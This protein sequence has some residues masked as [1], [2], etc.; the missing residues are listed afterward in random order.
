LVA[1]ADGSVLYETPTLPAVTVGGI[2]AKA[3]YSGL[4]P[5]YAGLFQVDIQV[6]TGAAQGDDVPVAISM[7]GGAAD[8]AT[9]SVHSK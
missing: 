9:V 2:A 7:S 5:G 6:P 8:T 1:P 4:V 3:L